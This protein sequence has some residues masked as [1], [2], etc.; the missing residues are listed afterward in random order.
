MS[1]QYL[2]T[3]ASALDHFFGNHIGCLRIL[4]ARG[5]EVVDINSYKN[6]FIDGIEGVI[7]SNLP[8]YAGVT[9]QHL[10]Q[11]VQV[12][13]RVDLSNIKGLKEIYRNYFEIKRETFNEQELFGK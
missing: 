3:T 1:T 8:E 11:I 13:K 7:K 9:N 6:K 5:V 10:V 4:Y 12:A 2:G